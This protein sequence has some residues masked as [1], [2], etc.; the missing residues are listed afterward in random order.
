MNPLNDSLSS[1]LFLETGQ[2]KQEWRE[3]DYPTEEGARIPVLGESNHGNAW[4]TV[5]GGRGNLRGSYLYQ[6][7]CTYTYYP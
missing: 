7:C 5:H 4:R 1:F 6:I 2:C 3:V